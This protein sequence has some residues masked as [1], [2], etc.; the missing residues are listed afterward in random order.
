MNH[1]YINSWCTNRSAC[2]SVLISLLLL[3]W[4][5]SA[6]DSGLGFTVSLCSK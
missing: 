6:W 5:L 2:V 4:W 3:Y 1:I